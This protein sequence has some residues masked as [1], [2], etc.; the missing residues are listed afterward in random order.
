LNAELAH[1][2]GLAVASTN[3]QVSQSSGGP[4][5]KNALCE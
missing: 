4:C 3:K 5:P 2:C 1:V